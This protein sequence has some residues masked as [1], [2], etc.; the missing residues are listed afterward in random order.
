MF[1]SVKSA[2]KPKS[3]LPYPTP[4]EVRALPSKAISKTI[5]PYCEMS[6]FVPNVLFTLCKALFKSIVNTS[7]SAF[8]KS[9]SIPKMPPINDSTE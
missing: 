7:P 5:S 6:I 3:A 4:I 2:L 9:I 1:S 8:A